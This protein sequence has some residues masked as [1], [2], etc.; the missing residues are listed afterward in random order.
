VNPLDMKSFSLSKGKQ[1]SLKIAL[2]SLLVDSDELSDK[3]RNFMKHK[4]DWSVALLQ[5]PNFS[6]GIFHNVS[7]KSL[8]IVGMKFF[9]CKLLPRSRWMSVCASST[10]KVMGGGKGRKGREGRLSMSTHQISSR[11]MEISAVPSDDCI[12]SHV[13]AITHIPISVSDYSVPR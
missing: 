6:L 5:R 4:I 9:I 11:Q 3:A 1:S 13:Q 8:C 10:F 2:K 7:M 12:L